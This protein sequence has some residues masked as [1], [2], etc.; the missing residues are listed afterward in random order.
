LQK[1]KCSFLAKKIGMGNFILSTSPL[2]KKT[3][4]KGFPRAEHKIVISLLVT[5]T[6][7]RYSLSLL[8]SNDHVFESTN[9]DVTSNDIFNGVTVALCLR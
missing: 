8:V 4:K 2:P 7:L 9:N 3:K 5:V 6:V 1:S